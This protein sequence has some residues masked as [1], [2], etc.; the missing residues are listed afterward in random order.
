MFP[1]YKMMLPT[2]ILVSLVTSYAEHG[3]D[4]DGSQ[5]LGIEHHMR[6]LGFTTIGGDVTAHRCIPKWIIPML[7]SV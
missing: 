7:L 3:L 1:G 2:G 5:S 6:A 4:S